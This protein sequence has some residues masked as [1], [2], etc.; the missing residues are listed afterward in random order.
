[1]LQDKFASKFKTRNFN[2]TCDLILFY[3]YILKSKSRQNLIKKA[4][5]MRKLDKK[6]IIKLAAVIMIAI[7][8]M[9]LFSIDLGIIPP[10]GSLL[11]PGNGLWKVPGEVP[12]E[13]RLTIP[14]LSADVTVI[15]DE[16]GIPHIYASNEED[17]S[18]ALGYCHAQDRFFQMDMARRSI[19]GMLSEI[20]GPSA[21][22]TDKFNLASGKMYWANESVQ[23]MIQMQEDGD[24]DFLDSVYSYVD[25]IN[26]FLELQRQRNEKPLEYYLLGF[27]PT[28]WSILDSLCFSKY[29]SEML[30]WQYGD[31]YNAI[32]LEAFGP[33]NYSEIFSLPTPYQ[34]PICPNYGEYDAPQGSF[35]PDYT[36]NPSISGT[37]KN[38]LVEVEKIDSQKFLIDAQRDNLIGSNNWVVDGV[39][40]STGKPILANDMHLAWAMPGIWYEAHLV[41]SDTGLNT[42]GFSVAG[43]STIVAG[44][45][46]HVAWGFTNVGY[47]VMDWYYYNKDPTNS[48]TNYIYNGTSTPYSTKTYTINVK[49]QDPI[50]F[51]VKET[52]HGPVLN[53]FL[54]SSITEGFGDVVLAPRWTASNVSTMF[55]ALYGFNHAKNRIEFD[56]ASKYFDNPAQNIVYADIEGNIAIRPTGLVPIRPGNGTFPYNGSA[57][58]GE[59]TGYIPFEEL[60]NTINPSQN[61]LASANQISAGPEYVKY[62]LQNE[63]SDGYRA[64]R[65]NE[66]LSKAPNGTVSVE[67]MKEIQNDVNSSSAQAFT[68]Y[69]I[70]AIETKYGSSPPEKIGN[71]LTVLKDWTYVMD[72]DLS[73]PTIYRK[74][75]DYFDDYTFD[76]EVETYGA[77]GGPGLNVLE[78]L[79]R[80]VSDS[81]WFDDVSTPEVETR[82]DIIL[83]A[84]DDTIE[85]LEREYDSSNPT[86]W[87]W[88]DIHTVYYGHLTGLE[89][90]SVGPFEWSG[91]GHCVTPSGVSIRTG[92]GTARGG[93]SERLIVD[94]SNLNNSISVIPSGQRGYSNS[95]HYSDQVENLFLLGKYHVQYFTN[96]VNNF[97][98]SSVESRIYFTAGGA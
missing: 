83:N 88:G 9:S 43:I 30:T 15:R 44:Q 67:K 3:L 12:A 14:G 91:S 80:E 62:F 92:V 32:D 61:Y 6:L 40:S 19:R 53:D 34:I 2:N 27:E 68:P 45:T 28:E 18:F 41:S 48:D 1:M 23:K 22:N 56:E 75:R 37:I 11:F 49:G 63:Y 38:F 59:W 51:V 21:L 52:V 85:W 71:V 24:I 57:G 64:R 20:I 10:L 42:Y 73:A 16:W 35:W 26:Y 93:A 97:P 82:D 70:N 89:A 4:I 69:L 55:N 77:S 95:K 81:H 65:I 36:P 39:K 72:K 86:T 54:G 17:L 8:S 94:F 98:T 29:F 13:E 7:I 87:R 74:W 47:D 78:Y 79:M 31:L 96:T 5:N 25:G 58:E 76:D 90:L 66:L 84:L 33:A 46:D 50:E 60:P